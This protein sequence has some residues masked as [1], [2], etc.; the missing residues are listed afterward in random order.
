MIHPNNV[1]QQT[2]FIDKMN[3]IMTNQK[4]FI[5]PDKKFPQCYFFYLYKMLTVYIITSIV[6]T[7]EERYGV[8]FQQAFS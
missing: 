3:P 8:D 2:D 4:N 5:L 6:E 7:G 1:N